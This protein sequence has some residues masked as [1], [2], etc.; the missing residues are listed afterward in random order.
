MRLLVQI[1]KVTNNLQLGKNK[2][3]EPTEL[4]NSLTKMLLNRTNSLRGQTLANIIEI[5]QDAYHVDLHFTQRRR[6]FFL[7]TSHLPSAEAYSEPL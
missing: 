7:Y 6:E 3:K 1:S 2:K 4:Q 5:F